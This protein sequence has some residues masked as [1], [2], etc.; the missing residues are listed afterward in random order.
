[1]SLTLAVNWSDLN[2]EITPG[3]VVELEWT[4]FVHIHHREIAF[5]EHWEE[6]GFTV[7][8]PEELTKLKSRHL[9][10]VHFV[11]WACHL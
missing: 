9:P 3:I 7:K 1:M 8:N 6:I 4:T 2:D 5:C 10:F 11:V